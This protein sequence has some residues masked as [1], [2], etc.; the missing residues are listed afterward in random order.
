MLRDL[1]VE[2]WE[3]SGQRTD[4]E[5]FGD[6]PTGYEAADVVDCFGT[7]YWLRQFSQAEKV[8]TSYSKR[9]IR[10]IRF[11]D[12]QQDALLKI[13]PIALASFDRGAI[14]APVV[15]GVDASEYNGNVLHF[16]GEYTVSGNIGTFNLAEIVVANFGL[17]DEQELVGQS[18]IIN[19][20]S[21]TIS[22]VTGGANYNI[23]LSQEV[24]GVVTGQAVDVQF[25]LDSVDIFILSATDDSVDTTF[26]LKDSLG[27]FLPATFD[28]EIYL[29]SIEIASLEINNFRHLLKV[30]NLD[31]ASKVKKGKRKESFYLDAANSQGVPDYWEQKGGRI[32]FDSSIDAELNLK[33]EVLTVPPELTDAD[34]DLFV[35]LPWE[36][37]LVAYVAWRT[38]QRSQEFD[39]AYAL[40]KE[41]ENL[42]ALTT[43]EAASDYLRDDTYGV[44]L[45][46]EEE[47]I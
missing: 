28:C 22:S 39:K 33:F 45:L 40:R 26:V 8:V 46:K 41:F 16:S 14:T 2:A 44:Y 29:N 5:P 19:E 35:S 21:Y 31:N 9:G 23:I 34:D 18:V 47:E 1:I 24:D 20:V 10:P 32:Y 12:L 37:A 25:N 43:P 4:L 17:D 3:L 42:M 30:V 15:A 7:R 13:E 38:A 36:P 11:Y 27:T 6:T